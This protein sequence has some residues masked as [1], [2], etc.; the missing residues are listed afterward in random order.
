MWQILVG[1][2]KA[3]RICQTYNKLVRRKTGLL[4]LQRE[5]GSEGGTH[6]SGLWDT[7]KEETGAVGVGS[8]GGVRPG[9]PVGPQPGR[10]RSHKLLVVDHLRGKE[11]GRRAE[12]G[13]GHS[14]FGLERQTGYI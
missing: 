13:L 7:L 1:V 5:R 11:R 9:A 6:P 2:E 10:Q 14:W 3:S 4:G 12:D 8:E